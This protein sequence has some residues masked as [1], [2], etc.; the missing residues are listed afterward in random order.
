MTPSSPRPPTPARHAGGRATNPSF[1]ATLT[2]DI[3]APIS[4]IPGPE[5]TSVGPSQFSTPS[6][7]FRHR[8]GIRCRT[9]LPNQ[10]ARSLFRHTGHPCD[11][12]QALPA[13]THRPQSPTRRHAR[14]AA[15]SR[16]L[17]KHPVH[18][19]SQPCLY[20]IFAFPRR[21]ERRQILNIRSGPPQQ[22]LLGHRRGLA[23][24]PPRFLRNHRISHQSHA[25]ALKPL[26]PHPNPKTFPAAPLTSSAPD[27]SPHQPTGT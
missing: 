9:G 21:K 27:H 25:K 5:S 1:A 26:T 23:R 8:R 14:L 18:P 24:R 20:G 10:L 13:I 15:P 16:G 22:L 11:L 6:R 4:A 19:L 17:R 12:P 3:D 7:R 2:G